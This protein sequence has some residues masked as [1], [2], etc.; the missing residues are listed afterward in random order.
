MR[1]NVN[2][3]LGTLLLVSVLVGILYFSGKA[4][5]AQQSSWS[6]VRTSV[7]TLTYELSQ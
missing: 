4:L 1:H 6:A 7:D 5:I 2:S 3:G